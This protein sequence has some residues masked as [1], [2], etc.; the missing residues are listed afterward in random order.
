MKISLIKRVLTSYMTLGATFGTWF[1]PILTGLIIL[2]IRIVVLMGRILDVLFFPQVFQNSVKK[3]IMIVG[4]P[5]SGTTFIHR[6]LVKNRIGIGS[7]LWQML[8][9]SIILQKLIKP[10]LPVLEK[11]SPTRHHSTVAHATSLQSIETDDAGIFFRFIDGFFHY[12]F[13]LAWSEENL[14]DW[15]DPKHRNTSKRDYRWLETMWLRNQYMAGIDRTVGKL[16]SLSVNLPEFLSEFPDSKVLYIIR[17]PMSVIPSGLSLI[18]GVLDKRFGFWNLPSEKRQHFI[19]RLYHGLMQL[20]LRFHDDW[21]NGRIDK[22][23]VFIVHFDRMMTDFD[24]L[25]DEILIF[26]DHLPSDK[27]IEDIHVTAEKQRDFKSAHEYDLGKFGLSG[28]QIKS[29]CAPIY[30]TF[31]NKK[32][33]ST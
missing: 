25:M 20:Q 29:D 30:E 1:S 6:F 18:T 17:D 14:F 11:V 10:F 16:F 3:P 12:G 19:D 2:I 24:N 26:I 28:D 7:Q 15:V 22:S 8:Y 13:I 9:P 27:L 21:I 33:I 4:N 31:L 23:R 5:R 32:I